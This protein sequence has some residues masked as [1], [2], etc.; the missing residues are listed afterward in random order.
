MTVNTALQSIEENCDKTSE[1]T[2]TNKRK[3]LHLS[4]ETWDEIQ[5]RKEA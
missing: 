4:D 5:K 1:K 3:K 2:G